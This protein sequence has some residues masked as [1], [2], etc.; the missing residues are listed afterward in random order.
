MSDR[1]NT[2]LLMETSPQAA[3][4]TSPAAATSQAT[5]P[6]RVRIPLWVWVVAVLAAVVH[7]APY[8]RAAAETPDGFVFTAN[9]SISPDYMQYRVWMRQTQHEG[10]I[11]SDIFTT[12]PNAAHLPVPL[13]W[14]F[15]K[16]AAWTGLTPEWT[17][18]WFGA[19]V[20][21]AFTLVLF[22]LTRRFLGQGRA[23][24]WAFGCLMI[25]G[26]LGGYFAL[27]RD[28]DWARGIYPINALLLRPISGEDGAVIF[29]NFAAIT[30]SRHCSIHIS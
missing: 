22:S 21:V 4:F 13:Y 28:S 12:E 6:T 7:M 29:E 18:A 11:V 17:Y 25:G 15:G 20:A 14:M 16:I 23:T 10:P 5:A 9:L 26:G 30:S 2:P 8:L 27:L 3:Q 1:S 19:L 24:V